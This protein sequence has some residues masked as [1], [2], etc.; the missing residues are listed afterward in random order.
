MLRQ[1]FAILK[2]LRVDL[3][4][5][6]KIITAAA[7]LHNIGLDW[8][9]PVPVDDHPNLFNIQE[10]EQPLKNKIKINRFLE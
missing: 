8:V 5:A 2:Y 4:N 6:I 10:P 1:R 7:V 3:P 9:D